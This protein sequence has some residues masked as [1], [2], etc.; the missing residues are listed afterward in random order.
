M[1]NRVYECHLLTVSVQK[2]FF[3]REQLAKLDTSYREF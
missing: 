2:L 3:F 1:N